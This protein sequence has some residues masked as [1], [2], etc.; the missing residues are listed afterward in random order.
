MVIIAVLDVTVL[1]ADHVVAVLLGENLLVFDRLDGGVV[2]VL[3]H[4]TVNGSLNILVVSTGDVLV[5]D[6]WVD[7]LWELA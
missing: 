4:L 2:M 7:G 1:Y 3:M 5:S 6:S